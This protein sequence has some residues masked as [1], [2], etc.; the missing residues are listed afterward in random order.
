MVSDDGFK[1][2]EGM[3][4]EAKRGLAWRKKY[5]RGG[6]LVGVARARDIVNGKRL[7]ADTVRRMA[8]FFARHEVDKQ[9][10]G[11]K[12]GPQFPSPGRIAWALWG[13]DAG[14]A[15]SKQI[16]E[17]LAKRGNVATMLEMRYRGFSI[18][19]SLLE[20]RN[21]GTG[22]GGFQPGNDCAR[23]TGGGRYDHSPGEPRI[24]RY[25]AK[26]GADARDAQGREYPPTV[27]SLAD[28]Q[29]WDDDIQAAELDPGYDPQDVVDDIIVEKF[30]D[31]DIEAGFSGTKFISEGANPALQEWMEKQGFKGPPAKAMEQIVRMAEAEAW[32]RIKRD[33]RDIASKKLRARTSTTYPPGK[34]PIR[35]WALDLQKHLL[36]LRQDCGTGDG[37]FKSGNDCAKNKAGKDGD[38]DGE[39]E[40]GREESGAGAPKT[41]KD[42]YEE[43]EQQKAKIQS[44]YDQMVKSKVWANLSDEDK[45]KLEALKNKELAAIQKKQIPKEEITRTREIKTKDGRVIQQTESNDTFWQQVRRINEQAEND[46]VEFDWN[47]ILKMQPNLSSN[48]AVNFYEGDA[49]K[50]FTTGEAPSDDD[51]EKLD[52]LAADEY[53][54]ITAEEFDRRTTQFI[55]QLDRERAVQLAELQK[56]GDFEAYKKLRESRDDTIRDFEYKLQREREEKRDEA[57]AEMRDKLEADSAKAVINGRIQLFR[58]LELDDDQID[59]LIKSGEVNHVAVNSW[60]TD[61]TVARNF[62]RGGVILVTSNA[63]VGII[64]KMPGDAG[65]ENEVIRP[66]SNMKIQRVVRTE[67]ATFIYVDEDDLYKD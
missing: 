47:K 12:P 38:G 44:Q 25:K 18:E 9:G 27:T 34:G 3:I 4:A 45:K 46:G 64:N 1:P 43:L 39:F 53:G 19:R 5:D 56:Q 28:R 41:P 50:V 2:T 66:P 58:G 24:S 62:A 48:A 65:Q 16:A 51:L 7:S 32:E 30:G 23:G 11:F 42:R 35:R 40:R 6:T 67:E 57:I 31:V 17:R 63:R 59:D 14:A 10:K 15:W 33:A 13:G 55:K 21:C 26:E 61:S 36:E 60:S 22:S 29:A 37:G 20:S 52:R 49:F 54:T 8:S